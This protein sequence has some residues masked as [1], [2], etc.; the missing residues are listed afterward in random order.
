MIKNMNDLDRATEF[1]DKYRTP[2]IYQLLANEQFSNNL[3]KESISSFTKADDFSKYSQVV[4]KAKETGCLEDLIP[5]IEQARTKYNDELLDTELLYAFAFLEKLSEL[6]V[7]LSKPHKANVSIFMN[8]SR[9]NILESCA[10]KITCSNP[11]SIFSSL[12]QIQIM[13]A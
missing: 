11:L 10:W 6:D 12:F 7:F 13:Y 1:A 3:I 2:F 9:L 8:N 4:P 5:Y